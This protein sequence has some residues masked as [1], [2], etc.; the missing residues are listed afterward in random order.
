[1]NAPTHAAVTSRHGNLRSIYA[2]LIAVAFFALMDAVLKVL[3]TRYPV[4][5]IAA[6]RAW[7]AMPLVLGFV[8]WRGGFGTAL[9]VRMPL[10]VLRGMLGIAMLS[11][12][13]LGVRTL[14]L[15]ETYAIFFIAPALMTALSTV[16]LKEKVSLQRWVAVAVCMGGVLVALRPDGAGMFSLGGLAV[17]GSAACYAVAAI[18]GRIVGRT[19]RTEHTVLWMMV[20]M[21]IGATVLALPVW[22]WPRGEDFLLLCALAVTGFLGQLAITEAFN[23]GEASVVAPFEYTALAYGVMI[24]WIIWHTLP[25]RYTLLGAAIIVG[26]GI[27]L[28]RHERDRG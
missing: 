10:H 18:V 17:L 23:S 7:T 9:R 5:V 4:I 6:M 16:I 20:Y 19:D 22:V 14:S 2:M 13:V 1:M 21:G 28:I 3:S 12:F 25:D 15:A 24:D 27:Y 26:S 8:A 11:L